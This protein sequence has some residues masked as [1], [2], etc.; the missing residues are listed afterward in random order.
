MFDGA[1]RSRR[2]LGSCTSFCKGARPL[3]ENAEENKAWAGKAIPHHKIPS[4][5]KD[6]SASVRRKKPG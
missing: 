1:G 5:K 6:Y 2:T 3:W 4:E